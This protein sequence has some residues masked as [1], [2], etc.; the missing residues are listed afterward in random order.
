MASNNYMRE[1]NK[2]LKEMHNLGFTGNPLYDFHNKENC[3]QDLIDEKLLQLLSMFDYEGLP[4]NFNKHNI[5]LYLLT[6]GFCAIIEHQ[7]ELW[8]MFGGLTGVP[9]SPVYQPT[10]ITIANPALNISGTYTDGVDCVIIR[11]DTFYNGVMDILSRY[12]TLLV[13]GNL[14]LLMW[15]NFGSRLTAAISSDDENTRQSA[16]DFIDNIIAGK[17]TT[18]YEDGLGEENIRVN[19]LLSAGT[20]G[21]ILQLLEM[22]QYIDAEFNKKFGLSSNNNRKREALSS[23]ETSTD[24][25]ILLPYIDNMRYY[26]EEGLDRVNKLFGTNW[27]FKKGSS[28]ELIEKEMEAVVEQLEVEP[29]EEQEEVDKEEEE[30]KDEA[31]S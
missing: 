25:S 8:P 31:D 3:L 10:Q 2:H 11:N 6:F 28:W 30:V 7:G 17:Y 19:P 26:R 23:D 5:E 29:E 1:I 22:L 9:K 18:I 4:Q 21:G 20:T 13:E 16:Q 27:S 15:S 24:D 12:C 14:S